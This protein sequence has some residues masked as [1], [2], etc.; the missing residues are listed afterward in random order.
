MALTFDGVTIRNG[1]FRLQTDWSM[2]TGARA[3]LIGA[4]GAGKSTLLMALAGFLPVETGRITWDGT[5]ITRADP[6][7]RPLTILFQDHNLFPHLDAAANVGLGIDPGLRLSA[8]DRARV[9]DTLAQ[10]GLDGLGNRKPRDLSGGQQGRV[11]LARA[12]VRKQPLLLLDE[13]FAALGPALKAEL[14][15]L[16]QDLCEAN[17]LTLLM[18]SH[19]PEDIRRICPATLVVDGG[20][21]SPPAPTEVL[22]SDPPPALRAY[23]G[24]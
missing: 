1:D 5:D 8:A 11:A 10:V 15:D 2:P 9:G 12:L 7:Q 18:V 3:G 22:F 20:T 19:D 6:G 16:V 23:L 14:L 17:G 13:P 24:K 4:S 21:A